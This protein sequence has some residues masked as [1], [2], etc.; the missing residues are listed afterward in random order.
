MSPPTWQ[1]ASTRLWSPRAQAARWS[2]GSPSVPALAAP[3]PTVLQAEDAALAG[4]AS[5]TEL[6]LADGGLAVDGVG[7]EP[8]NDSSLTFRV[9]A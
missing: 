2:T 5:A 7:G 4:G 9:D 3:K 8:G 1:A 6:S